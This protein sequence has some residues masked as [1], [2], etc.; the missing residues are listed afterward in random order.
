MKVGLHGLLNGR[1]QTIKL[2]GGAR[3]SMNLAPGVV[4]KN[5]SHKRKTDPKVRL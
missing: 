5:S 2:I 4:T 1:W 3:A